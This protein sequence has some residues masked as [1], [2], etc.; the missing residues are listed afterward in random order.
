MKTKYF[1]QLVSQLNDDWYLLLK[2]E[3]E[4]PYFITLCKKLSLEKAA[5]YPA[6]QDTFKALNLCNLDNVKVVIL[7]QDPYHN[8][9][10]ANGLCFSVPEGMTIPPSLRN[11]I[12]ELNQDLGIEL[13]SG[14]LSGWA[15]QGVLLLNAALSVEA[16]SASSHLT[17]GW[18]NFTD[19]IIDLVQFKRKDV[20]FL[21]WGNY[22]RKKKNRID[23]NKHCI[24]EAPHP[25]PLSAHRG[26]FGSKV[27]SKCNE[28]LA[29]SG[30][31]RIDWKK[32]QAY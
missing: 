17:W 31:T 27:F 29:Q 18:E 10:Q 3:L 19:A 8:E 16:H 7:G 9:G 13:K 11:I 20:V 24:I 12:K 21:L 25:S 30:K 32:N 15:Q 2:A 23:Q 28:Y 26:F 4:K 14:D 5:I 1:T 22:A 6:S